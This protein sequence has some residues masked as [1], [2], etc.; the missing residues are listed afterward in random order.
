[1]QQYKRIIENRGSRKRLN[2]IMVCLTKLPQTS[3]YKTCH[4]ISYIMEFNGIKCY[5]MEW[6]ENYMKIG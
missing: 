4:G 3:I 6:K 1:M 5:I 2:S